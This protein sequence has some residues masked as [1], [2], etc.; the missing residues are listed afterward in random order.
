MPPVLILPGLGSSGPAHWQTLWE[1]ANSAFIR[2][3]QRDWDK[4]DREDWIATLDRA[5]AAQPAPPLLVAHSLACALVAHWAATHARALHGAMLVAPADVDSAERTPPEVRDFSPMPLKPIPGRCIVV[6]SADDPYVEIA[7][8][9]SFAKAW[10]ALLVNAG[11]HG[12]INSASGLGDWLAGQRLLAELMSR[13]TEAG[14]SC[15][16]Q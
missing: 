16:N 9:A 4:P 8:A 10:G 1:K 6:A 12:H 13:R 5:I 15:A 3:E 11:A 14:K 2:V 7:R